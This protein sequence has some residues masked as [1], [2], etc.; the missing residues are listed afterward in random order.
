MDYEELILIRQEM[1]EEINDYY[2]QCRHCEYL[3]DCR[4]GRP[5]KCD[6]WDTEVL[7]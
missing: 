2:D 4:R 1:A 7:I 6:E 3:E 5:C